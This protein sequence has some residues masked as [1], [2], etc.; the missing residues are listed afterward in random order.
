MSVP[1]RNFAAMKQRIDQLLEE[2]STGL[3]DKQTECALVLLSAIAGESILLLG[4]PGIGKSLIARR[5]K[6]VFKNA[7]SFEYLMSRFSTPDEIFGP[8]SIRKMKDEDKYERNVDGYMPTADVVFL[9]EIWKAGPAIQN[10][11][12]TAIN[13]KIYRNGEKDIKL[14]M[15]VLIGASNELPD[16]DAGLEALWDRFIVR[17]VCEGIS[18]RADFEKMILDDQVNTNLSI[19]RSVSEKEYHQWQ[20]EILNVNV[21]L[22][23]LDSINS[24]REALKAVTIQHTDENGET[25]NE[26]CSVYV[27]DRRWKIIIRLLRTSALMQGRNSVIHSDLLLLKFCLWQEIEHIEPINKIII[28]SIFKESTLALLNLKKEIKDY[29]RNLKENQA[30][31]KIII[32][33]PNDKKKIFDRF[34][35]HVL[36]HGIGNTCIAIADYVNVPIKTSVNRGLGEHGIIY[37]EKTGDKRYIIRLY[38]PIY[39]SSSFPEGWRLTNLM[40]DN[41]YLYLDGVKYEIEKI[42]DED[43][44]TIPNNQLE[45]PKD[46]Y[47]EIE[48][49]CTQIKNTQKGLASNLFYNPKDQKYICD[50]VDKLNK[51]IAITRISISKTFSDE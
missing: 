38:D 7:K 39:R 29:L 10:S 49:I 41:E 6:A 50:F 47:K 44:Q 4:P 1:Y 32:Q 22:N 42:G 12:L 35:Y 17:M 30:Y 33:D 11:L 37:Q 31:S 27:S 43:K 15:K 20:S 28:R 23:I 21:P 14:P 26:S 51:E 46:F 45:P 13:E 36:D 18:K 25:E 40:R 48:D 8:V 24:I 19:K 34:Y 3:Y 5:A 9:D 2:M 16:S